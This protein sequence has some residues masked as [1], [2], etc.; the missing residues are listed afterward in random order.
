MHEAKRQQREDPVNVLTH[1]HTAGGGGLRS[2]AQ[3]SQL[4]GHLG[5]RGKNATMLER[6][7]LLVDTVVKSA[8]T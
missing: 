7:R 8:G 4:N 5:G 2:G 6:F 1:T 3:A